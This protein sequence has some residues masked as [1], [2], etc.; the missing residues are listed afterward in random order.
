MWYEKFGWDENVFTT[1]P[2]PNLIG[3]KKEKKEARSFAES[4]RILLVKGEIGSG[5][6]SLLLWLQDILKDTNKTPVILKGTET[7]T[8]EQLTSSLKKCRGLLERILRRKYPKNPVILLDEGD[9][10]PESVTETTRI[11]WDK[12]EVFSI[13]ITVTTKP[14]N[15]SPAFKDRIGKTISLPTLNK[16]DLAEVIRSRVGDKNPFTPE[17]I[18]IIA[19]NSS[20]SPRKTLEYCAEI[21]SYCAEKGMKEIDRDTVNEYMSKTRQARQRIQVPRQGAKLSPVQ[22]KIAKVI[23]EGVNTIGEIAKELDMSEATARTQVKRMIE[24]GW[25]ESMSDERPKKYRLKAVEE[26]KD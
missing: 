23:G 21:C 20:N 13:I 25:V 10:V 12:K 8:K 4:G 15:F 14:Q 17:A 5:K 18:I 6:T 16:G 26:V 24:K 7:K 9:K 19:E 22:E 2:N 11:M 3:L 1:K